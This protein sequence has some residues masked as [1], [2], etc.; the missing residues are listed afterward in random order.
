LPSAQKKPMRQFNRQ[1]NL[2]RVTKKRD[3]AA[4]TDLLGQQEAPAGDIEARIKAQADNSEWFENEPKAIVEFVGTSSPVEDFKAMLEQSASSGK[5]R[6]NEAVSGIIGV[7]RDFVGPNGDELFH[8]KAL[9]C[10]KSFREGALMYHMEPKYNDFMFSLK[11]GLLYEKGE[12]SFWKKLVDDKVSL[13]SAEESHN[14]ENVSA[15]EAQDF[16]ATASPTQLSTQGSTQTLSQP[17]IFDDELFDDM[18]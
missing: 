16:L 13:I 17:R 6:S 2:R 15:K 14:A 4:E 5:D 9:E 10:V 11:L 18:E 12:H 8:D 7:I 3:R 1:F